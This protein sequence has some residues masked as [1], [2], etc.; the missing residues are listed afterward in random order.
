MKTEI[1]TRFLN[2]DKKSLILKLRSLGA[3]DNGENKLEDIIFYDKDLKWLSE[4][5]LVKLRKLGDITKLILK[6]NKEQEVDSAK[7]IEFSVS[8][9]SEA[10]SFLEALGLVVSRVVEKYRHSFVLDR[11]TVDIDTWPKI[12][13][14][15]EL[16]GDSV[17]DLKSVANKLGL[18]W[19]DRFDGD[20]RF[21]YKKYGFDFDKIKTVTFDKFE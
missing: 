19:E 12:P 21:V 11:V 1:E 3:K 13:V 5:K 16:E 18:K 2:I 9:L 20:P 6:Q 8:S 4:N 14:Y 17:E 10:K 7:E 15:V